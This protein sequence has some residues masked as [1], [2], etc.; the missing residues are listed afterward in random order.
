M[1][2]MQAKPQLAHNVERH[3]Q[4][5]LKGMDNLPVDITMA[6]HVQTVGSGRINDAS[7]QMQQVEYNEEQEH[8][9]GSRHCAGSNGCS[10][11]SADRV[12]DRAST[13]VSQAELDG[14]YDV[15]DNN[16]Q[17]PDTGCPEQDWHF[18][19]KRRI[20]I[21]RMGSFEYLKISQ[22]VEDDIADE[23]EPAQG[24]QHFTTD[25][26]LEMAKEAR[27]PSAIIHFSDSR[28]GSEVLLHQTGSN[29]R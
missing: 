18:T 13:M 22:H 28:R 12:T 6:F 14:Q 4:W 27:H 25:R 29:E 21:E 11:I 20:A 2:D 9:P 16:A 10:A 1:I 23:A 7:R 8:R 17:Q 24:Q 3:D 26:G 19:E 15:Q 5:I